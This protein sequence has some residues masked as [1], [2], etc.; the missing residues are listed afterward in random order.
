MP[1]QTRAKIQ[2]TLGGSVSGNIKHIGGGALLHNGEV[3]P[4]SEVS[5]P[6]QEIA[7]SRARFSFL[8]LDALDRLA[9]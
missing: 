5:P 6:R 3:L 2:T 8:S 1:A 4:E 7:F 9:F